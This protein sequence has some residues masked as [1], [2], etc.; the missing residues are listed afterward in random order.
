VTK[1]TVEALLSLV[2]APEGF[3][4]SGY[5]VDQQLRWSC[6]IKAVSH[7]VGA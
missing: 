6:A 1:P 5:R 4:P 2:D 7:G 3:G